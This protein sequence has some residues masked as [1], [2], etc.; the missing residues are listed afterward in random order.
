M[1]N[2]YC[3]MVMPEKHKNILTYN[4]DRKSLKVLF[5]I[6]ADAESLLEKFSCC[7]I[8]REKFATTKT[9]KNKAS[10]I[11]YI[12]TVNLMTEKKPFLQKC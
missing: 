11:H 9:S 3:H 4:Q 8:N 7:D 6:Y 10:V 12:H 2:D 1:D 5:A